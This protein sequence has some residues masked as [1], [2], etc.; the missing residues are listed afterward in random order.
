LAIPGDFGFADVLSNGILYFMV[1]FVYGTLAPVT[2]WFMAFCFIIMISGYRNQLMFI[3]PP[4]PDSGGQLWIQFFGIS[5]TMVLIAEITI[6]GYL[7]LKKATIAVPLMIPLIVI[8][9][10]FNFY[11]RQRHFLVSQRLPSRTAL[12]KDLQNL[13]KGP[14]DM[15]FVRRKY[16]QKA[17]QSKD[18]L[19][20]ENFS[21]VREI[22]QQHIVSDTTWI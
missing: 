20:P 5:Q 17:L 12:K 10:L 18:P 3:Y 8:T 15:S 16:L 6:F 21:V 4:T 9:L 7:S 19:Y 2:N 22:E 14:L 13:E 11:I 1:V